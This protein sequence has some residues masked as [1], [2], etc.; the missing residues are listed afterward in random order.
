MAM[1]A[2][3]LHNR[4][5]SV[6]GEGEGERESVRDKSRE[7]NEVKHE[8]GAEGSER[9]RGVAVAAGRREGGKAE[10]EEAAV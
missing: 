5:L 8:K 3:S 1:Y 6:E 2:V 10:G 7:R 9:H 4:K